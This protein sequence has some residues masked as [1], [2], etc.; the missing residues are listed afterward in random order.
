MLLEVA[1]NLI[2][3]AIS[4]MP[5]E[6]NPLTLDFCKHYVFGKQK[7]RILPDELKKYTLIQVVKSLCDFAAFSPSTRWGNAE[8]YPYKGDQSWYTH[9][10]LGVVGGFIYKLISYEDKFVIKCIDEWDFNT[11]LS[12]NIPLPNGVDWALIRP[13]LKRVLGGKFNPVK[14]EYGDIIAFGI[15]ESWLAQFNADHKFTTT[16]ELEL[17]SGMCMPI[18]HSLKNEWAREHRELFRFRQRNKSKFRPM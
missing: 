5:V 1:A 12:Y 14:D 11:H 3:K 9:P 13:V 18:N 8:W 6:I 15:S 10:T 16:W 17:P 7:S 2:I 4:A